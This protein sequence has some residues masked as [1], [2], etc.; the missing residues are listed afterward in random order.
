MVKYVLQVYV[1]TD[2]LLNETWKEG[3]NRWAKVGSKKFKQIKGWD[4]KSPLYACGE[5]FS[6]RLTNNISSAKTYNRLC[7]CE[8]YSYSCYYHL[9]KYRGFKDY[10]IVD[11]KILKVE[12]RPVVVATIETKQDWGNK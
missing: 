5:R 11:V 1:D 4:G 12:M 9:I 8:H 3:E 10:P 2:R 7:D 6:T